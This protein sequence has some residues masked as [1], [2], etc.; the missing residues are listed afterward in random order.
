MKICEKCKILFREQV[1]ACVECRGELLEITL[2]QALDQL[3]Q[4]SLRNYMRSEHQT[5]T[6]D[7]LQYHIRCY[8][9]NRSLFLDFDLYKNRLKHGRHEKTFFIAPVN[10][11]TVINLPWF[12]FNVI[13]SNFFHMQYTAYCPRCDSKCIPGQHSKEECA[14][15]IE[16]FHILEDILSGQIGRRRIVYKEYAKEKQRR[17]QRSA[18]AELFERPVR[19]EAFGD[20]LSIGGTILFWIFIATYI[21]FPMAQVLLQKIQQLDAYEWTFLTLR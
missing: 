7:K 1:M 15:N 6:E 8:L 11:T 16:Y 2:Q 12:L 10:I 20:L 13:E 21:S 17:G 9:A 14:Y 18:Y 4:K 5:L 3:E 19:W